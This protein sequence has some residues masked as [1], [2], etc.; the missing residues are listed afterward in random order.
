MSIGRELA[1]PYLRGLGTADRLAE[2]EETRPPAN[3][4]DKDSNVLYKRVFEQEESEDV[5]HVMPIICK[6]ER[7][8]DG[9]EM[10]NSH[11]C[12]DH[13][14]RNKRPREETSQGMV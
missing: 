6:G 9:I 4:I 2:C 13:C 12:Q 1:L 5:E 8:D 11:H 3:E 7:V 10:D 14:H